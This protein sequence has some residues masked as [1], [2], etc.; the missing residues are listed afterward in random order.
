[1][2]NFSTNSSFSGTYHKATLGRD[3]PPTIKDLEDQEVKVDERATFEIIIIEDGHPANY[4]FV[5]EVSNDG[6]NTWSTVTTGTG[7]NTSSYTTPPATEGMNGYLY[8]CK[9]TNG[10]SV[11]Y[12]REARLR[13]ISDDG[14][15]D[16]RPIVRII[17]K[18]G[19]VV[20]Y[21]GDNKFV[22]MQ[23]IIKSYTPLE[24][25][26]LSFDKITTD[27]LQS[28]SNET[29]YKV[30]QLS[31]STM[32]SELYPDMVEYTYSADLQ[33]KVNGIAVVKCKDEAGHDSEG[34]QTIDI[35]YDIKV[36]KTIS[37]LSD[38]NNELAITFF[39]NRPVRFVGSTGYLVDSRE[40]KTTETS[41]YAL[42]Y[43]YT[44]PE[45][46]PDTVF[47]FEDEYKNKASCIV[48]A[49]TRV[50]YKDIIFNNEGEVID[51]LSVS[52]AYSIAQG[53]E[54]ESE[55]NENLDSQSRYGVNRAQIDMFMGRA[56]DLGAA[57]ILSDATSSK[58]FDGVMPQDIESTQVKDSTYDYVG[59]TNSNYVSTVGSAENELSNENKAYVDTVGNSS[60]LYKGGDISGFQANDT[61]KPY[62]IKDNNDNAVNINNDV[63]NATFRAIIVGN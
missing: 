10:S 18:N 36:D 4:E 63:N 15:V 48:E 49:V 1:L 19:R 38:S 12:S 26:T 40:L 39:A 35:I 8:R 29:N 41:N 14:L 3:V 31:E 43:T 47:N 55:I 58:T 9:I 30:Y 46:I 62:M 61:E 50:K 22:D 11:I 6:G 45:S 20:R 5:W 23:I 56:R 13:V 59:N 27:I 51:D 17:Y 57:E 21:D 7:G 32:S 52:D 42:K 2:D 53:L 44:P 16:Q 28:S 24:S 37:K 54:Q 25:A 33:T 34:S 60:S